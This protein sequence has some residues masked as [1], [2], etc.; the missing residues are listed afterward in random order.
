[1]IELSVIFGLYVIGSLIYLYFKDKA[2]QEER[3]ELQD[4]FMALCNSQ[5]LLTHKATQDSVPAEVKYE[6]EADAEQELRA[7]QAGASNGTV[8]YEDE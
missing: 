8:E 6:D 1:M 4:R 7:M 3:E 5:A 2:T